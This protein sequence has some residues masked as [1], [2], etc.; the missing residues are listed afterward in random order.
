MTLFFKADEFV[1]VTR[2]ILARYNLLHQS[3]SEDKYLTSVDVNL[4][5]LQRLGMCLS[6]EIG[7]INFSLVIF[8]STINH[9]S[10]RTNKI[11][12]YHI[13]TIFDSDRHIPVR[14]IAKK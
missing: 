1:G 14:A 10:G 13:L 11:T 9:D 12:N 7:L 5:I 3:I 2:E 4:K 6:I 8:H